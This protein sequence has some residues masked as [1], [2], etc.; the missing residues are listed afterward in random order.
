MPYKDSIK[1]KENYTKYDEEKR[2]HAYNS[3]K[4]GKFYIKINGIRGVIQLK[5]MP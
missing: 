3:I 2:Q 1:K 5:E 4:T